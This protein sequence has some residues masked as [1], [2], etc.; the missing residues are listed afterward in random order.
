MSMILKRTLVVCLSMTMLICF[1]APTSNAD[2]KNED[3]DTVRVYFTISDDSEFL[4]GNDEDSTVMARV[5][6][7][8]P[9]V[10]LATYHLED[11]YRY[12]AAPFEQGGA[13]NSTVVVERPT[14]LMCYLKA[15]SIYYL[16]REITADDI[17]YSSQYS[18]E[19][20]SRTMTINGSPTSLYL[21]W[22]WGHFYNF[23]YFVNHEYPLMAKG[24]GA[25]A[26][27]I[28]LEDGDEIDV[29]MF[30]DTR[31]NTYGGFTY[32]DSGNEN[33]TA[34]EEKT[35]TLQSTKTEEAWNDDYISVL[36]K[37]PIRVSKDYGRTWGK[38]AYTTDKQGQ[39]TVSFD[40][41]GVYYLSAGP[42]FKNQPY[43][44]L[45]CMAPPICV[46]EVR[47]APVTG[48]SVQLDGNSFSVSWA[49][50]PGAEAY[51]VKY[52]ASTGSMKTITTE[53]TSISVSDAD[54]E[55]VSFVVRPY[56]TSKY[57]ALGEE[58]KKLRGSEVTI[59]YD[60]NA[61]AEAALANA[62]TAAKEE[63]TAYK[64]GKD[65]SLYRLEQQNELAEILSGGCQAI[66]SA[67][68]EAGVTTALNATKRSMD[69]VKTDAELTREEQEGALQSAIASACSELETYVDP[70]LYRDNER[71]L[72]VD[73][74]ID[75]KTNIQ[76]AQDFAGVASALAD[77]KALLDDVK[78]DAEYTA[79]EQ[80]QG[81]EQDDPAAK[82]LAEAKKNA[83]TDL[84]SYKDSK[85]LTLY[86]DEQ[87]EE[88]AQ[89]V[90]QGSASIDG[91]Q[92]TDE[93]AALLTE[94]KGKLDEVK[95]DAQMTEEEAQAAEEA[96]KKLKEAKDNAK[97]ELG[98]YMAPEEYRDAEKALLL[99]IL[100]EGEAAINAASTE[101]A[102]KALLAE[103]KAKIDQLKT[104]A[105]Y[106][107]EEEAAR[108]EE[109][110]K[111]KEH[112]AAVRKAK[113]KAA[114]AAKLKVIA[115]ALKK[116]K[117]EVRWK[118]VALSYTVDGK[119]YTGK[120]T[121]Y[122]VYRAAKKNGKYKLIKTVK[123]AVTLKYT[124]KKL[125][126]SKKYFYKVRTYTTINGRT[127]L[128]KWSA[129]KKVTA[130]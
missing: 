130:K 103:Y 14:L 84:A 24:W 79:E 35:L 27:Y 95:T 90:E 80:G 129:A 44:Q 47:P 113:I 38:N 54:P 63:L 52:K 11:F 39:F 126:K 118:K 67:V 72:I 36:K 6:V 107:A 93:V 116:H 21:L 99:E 20:Q 106:T 101:E 104:D 115:K 5:P 53:E 51:E 37:E 61:D 121:G 59:T 60:P 45:Q 74:I 68:D 26:D 78:T 34:G 122:K 65:L 125:K 62:K 98:L 49:E 127:Y 87:K 10:D 86:R 85:D 17:S 81:G 13:Y 69:A 56:V 89:I 97:V 30:T 16:G 31:F 76:Q 108:K 123:K 102:V 19:G 88:L 22:F 82:A 75:G 83:K 117:A 94:Y 1:L 23:M 25:T 70:A 50:S 124:D 46:V 73:I 105:E 43:S 33:L 3:V 92:A 9:Y 2:T 48:E 112:E 7:D 120:V 18:G 32:F 55:D 77:A 42:V 40:E 100:A 15:L 109:E 41:A 28:L 8:V 96:A 128:G 119:K 111:K 66:D 91:A 57:V 29:A 110:R 71:Q 12:E 64:N 4:I 58:Y 114:K